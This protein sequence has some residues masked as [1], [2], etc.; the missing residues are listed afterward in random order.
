MHTL[1]HTQAS[2]VLVAI[3]GMHHIQPAA[4]SHV[5]GIAGAGKL[6]GGALCVPQWL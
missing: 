4:H 5:I 1:V 6:L 2:S 3:I